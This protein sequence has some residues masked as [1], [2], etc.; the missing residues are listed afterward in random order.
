[1]FKS[2]KLTHVS[3]FWVGGL[4]I[5]DPCSTFDLTAP[6]LVSQPLLRKEGLAR[7]TID[8]TH[9]VTRMCTSREGFIWKGSSWCRDG[10][11]KDA[12]N[13]MRHGCLP[14]IV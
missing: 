4:N 14:K 9:K 5:Y 10:I 1:M 7:E 2:V 8:S 11:M 3:V 6:S 13:W 12:A